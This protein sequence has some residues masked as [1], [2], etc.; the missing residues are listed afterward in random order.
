MG[1]ALAIKRNEIPALVFVAKDPHRAIATYAVDV[2]LA[3]EMQDD[4][5]IQRGIAAAHRSSDP[6]SHPGY[7][8]HDGIVPKT[9]KTKTSE[10]RP[11]S[12][13]DHGSDVVFLRKATVNLNDQ[14]CQAMAV[15]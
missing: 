3:I 10:S 8:E 9:Q 1:G 2:H 5:E 12:S 7:D 6:G 13:E 15:P 4:S 11:N 14:H